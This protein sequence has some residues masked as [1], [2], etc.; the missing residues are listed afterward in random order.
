VSVRALNIQ[1]ATKN[2]VLKN[3]EKLNFQFKD[4]VVGSTTDYSNLFWLKEKKSEGM[5]RVSDKSL[6]I[7]PEIS[8]NYP[9]VFT[10]EIEGTQIEFVKNISYKF[11][12]PDDGETYVSEFFPLE[13]DKCETAVHWYLLLVLDSI[14]V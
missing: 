12:N 6:R 4:C 8:S 3:N 9:V 7:L 10:L 13:S 2:V 1:D 5:Y 11:N 14:L